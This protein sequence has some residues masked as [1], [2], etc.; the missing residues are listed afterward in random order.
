M[1]N[2]NKTIKELEFDT[3]H[4]RKIWTRSAPADLYYN[5]DE[6]DNKIMRGTNKLFELCNSFKEKL[7][8]RA[9]MA[10]ALQVIINFFT[11]IHLNN[12]IIIVLFNIK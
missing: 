6:E 2:M 10:R 5:R 4:E 12:I 7:L 1:R 3:G 11:I 8:D 9:A